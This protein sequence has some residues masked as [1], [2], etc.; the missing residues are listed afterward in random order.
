L[1]L[2]TSGVLPR[3]VCNQAANAVTGIVKS[4][5]SLYTLRL[6]PS[7]VPYFVLI[8]AIIHLVAVKTDPSNSEVRGKLL[9]GI[10]DLEEM[11]KCHAFALRA[12]DALRY[13]AYVWDVDVS[14][15][16]GNRDLTDFYRLSSATPDQF[17]P[18]TSILQ[19]LQSIQPVLSSKDHFLFSPFPTQGL[20]SVAT[21]TQ[22]EQG[23]FT[24]VSED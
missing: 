12:I 17:S 5:A 1:K 9:Q 15:S 7:F 13:L 20:P 10:S 2:T 6:T 18:D 24:V 22:L 3:D 23:G 11:A 4:Y 8:S 16:T 21:G 19:T 14:F